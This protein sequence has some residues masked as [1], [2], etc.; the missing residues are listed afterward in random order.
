MAIR[1]YVGARY[2]PKF[3]DP[4]EWQANTSYEAM[5]IVT[6]NNSSYTSKIPVPPTVGNPAENSTYWALTGNYN[7]Q[8]EEYRQESTKSV[9]GICSVDEKN[10]VTAAY[11]HRPNEYFWWKGKLYRA[12]KNIDVGVTLSVNENCKKENVATGVYVNSSNITGLQ[13]TVKSNSDDITTVKEKSMELERNIGLVHVTAT[14][15]SDSINALRT[16]DTELERDIRNLRDDVSHNGAG[17]ATN[18]TNIEALQT[19]QSYNT[20][21]ISELKETSADHTNKINGLQINVSR[22]TSKINDLTS[23]INE[24]IKYN[25]YTTN[26]QKYPTTFNA[27]NITT[28]FNLSL[29]DI[30]VEPVPENTTLIPINAV[31]LYYPTLDDYNDPKNKGQR[32]IKCTTAIEP[33]GTTTNKTYYDFRIV[34]PE[35]WTAVGDYW[36]M[37]VLEIKNS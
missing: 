19:N 13:S 7:A 25:V 5:M 32:L 34:N 14:G 30:F 20:N 10:N 17:I 23:T 9:D 11:T 12:T 22:N 31:Y 1:N 21:G 4:V 3:A 35:A 15:N 6:Y 36:V 24:H 2:V 33:G 27:D 28:R 37:G 26:K 29:P 18:K 16:K 8:V